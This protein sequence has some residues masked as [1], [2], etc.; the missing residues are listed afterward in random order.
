MMQESETVKFCPV[1]HFTESTQKTEIAIRIEEKEVKI[2]QP[3]IEIYQVSSSGVNKAASLD[4][5]FSYLVVDRNS[6]VIWIWKGAKCSPGESYKAGI[7]STKLKSSLKLYSA[8]IIRIEEGDEPEKFP[9]IGLELAVQ[10][11]EEARKREEEVLK[12]EEIAETKTIS[13]GMEEE[14]VSSELKETITSLTL[15][16]GIS[17]EIAIK[18]F[19]ADISTIM[20]LSLSD[21][22][23]LSI[24]SGITIDIVEEIIRNA[25]ELLGID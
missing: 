21:S 16:R 11:E 8:N 24:K 9:K 22:D 19:N 13:K 14:E 4:S 17:R 2:E 1:C 6:N 7:E 12:A 3:K 23:S 15:I 18:L 10:V 5:N 20:E 25:K